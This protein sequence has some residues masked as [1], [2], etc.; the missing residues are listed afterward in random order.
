MQ[1]ST[2]DPLDLSRRQMPRGQCDRPPPLWWLNMGSVAQKTKA[3][4]QLKQMT[5][6][7]KSTNLKALVSK[8]E[9]MGSWEGTNMT[10]SKD[11]E[12][13]IKRS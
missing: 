8:T 2:S 6:T 1:N 3:E 5:K 9:P 10:I 4:Q 13:K 12:D 11:S 7:K